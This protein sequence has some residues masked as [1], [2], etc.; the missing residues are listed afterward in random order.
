MYCIAMHGWYRW[1][2]HA[3]V[4]TLVSSYKLYL[5]GYLYVLAEKKVSASATRVSKLLA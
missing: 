4:H 1:T 5:R 3:W 2:T